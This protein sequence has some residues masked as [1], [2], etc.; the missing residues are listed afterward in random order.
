M[1]IAQHGTPDEPHTY[2]QV[3][4]KK[5]ISKSLHHGF[6][7]KVL[8]L[9]FDFDGP[10]ELGGLVL[11]PEYREHEAR[12]GRFLSFVRFLYIAARKPYFQDEILVEL[13]PPVNERGES[14]LWEEIG[15]KFTNMSYME[16]DRLSRK[17]KEFITSLFP[18]G[19]IYTCMLSSE[20]R[21]AIGEVHPD[22]LPVKRMLEKLG[23]KYRNQIDP[24]DG[25]PHY[26]AKT[27]QV[28]P[29]KNTKRVK[30]ILNGKHGEDLCLVMAITPQGS[31]RAIQTE[32]SL[33]KKAKLPTLKLS[34]DQVKGLG[35]EKTQEVYV[36]DLT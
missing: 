1:V 15:R 13:M 31:V 9:A 10:T 7:H 2:F 20:A 3:M 6:L 27:S 21:Q 28:G 24:F 30:P 22:T 17:N 4:E 18:E 32:C 26:W 16:A 12:L 29:I 36:Y 33:E 5:K 19:D 35:F 34:R 14:P 11:L 8:R 25:G 23:F